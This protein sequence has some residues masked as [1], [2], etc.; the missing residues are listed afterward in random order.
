MGF[1]INRTVCGATAFL[2]LASLGLA[3]EISPP[4]QP[5]KRVT[6][7]PAAPAPAPTATTAKVKAKAKTTKAKSKETQPPEDAPGDKPVSPEQEERAVVEEQQKRVGAEVAKAAQAELSHLKYP[8]SAFEIEYAGAGK[9]AGKKLPNTDQ[10]LSVSV[11]LGRLKG[12]YADPGA[13]SPEVLRL[14]D[15]TTTQTFSAG[16]I[17]AISSAVVQKFGPKVASGVFVVPDPE[18]ISPSTG[19]DL[20][21]GGSKKLKLLVYVGVVKE[22][23]TVAKGPSY[24]PPNPV[25]TER[26]ERIAKNSPIKAGELLEK[27]VLQDYLSRVNR[28]PGRRADSSVSASGEPGAVYL[29]YLIREDKPWFFY[30]QTSNTGT[31]ESG[32]WRSRVGGTLRQLA[33]IDDILNA[34]YSVSELGKTRAVNMAYEFAPVFPDVLKVSAFGS[35]ADFTADQ[36]GFNKDR[37][38]GSSSSAGLSLTYTPVVIHGYFVDTLLGA[39]WRNVQVNNPAAGT[40]GN[41][42]FFVPYIGTAVSKETEWSN[43]A[44]MVRLET[45][46]SGVAGTKEAELPKLG[47][48]NTSKDFVIGHWETRHSFYLEPVIDRLAWLE[49]KDWKKARQVHELAFSGRAQYVFGNKR[50]VPQ[51]EDIVGGFSTVRGYPQS[52]TVGDNTAMGSAEYRFHF[53]RIL[54]PSSEVD[55]SSP[56]FPSQGPGDA[57]QAGDVKPRFATRPPA[58]LAKPDW[59]L[60][61]RTFFDAGVAQNNQ[62]DPNTERDRTLAGAGLGAELQV[63][64]YLNLRCDWGFALKSVSD[65][66]MSRPVKAGDNTVYMQASVVW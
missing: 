43:F 40:K 14:R 8:V 47:R 28:Y 45:N 38:T 39:A 46:L 10:L 30:A 2:F 21:K 18:Q 17:Q 58:I 53:P 1:P 31:P 62:R 54:R 13:G 22:V 55:F 52:T 26:Y 60:I 48:F 61:L 32:L 56:V 34:E 19:A 35:Y 36:V 64:R 50:V 5:V 29:D 25:N 59:D 20:R 23:R 42:D 12:A 6:L 4:P 15:L 57:V 44:T 11:Q 24:E 37:F 49:A 65:R 66:L 41:V 3:K 27:P 9:F 16:A 33:G 51:L 7:V 63:S